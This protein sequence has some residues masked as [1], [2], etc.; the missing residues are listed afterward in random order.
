MADLSHIILPDNTAIDLKMPNI[1]TTYS[2]LTLTNSSMNNG[3]YYYK[4][5]S[6]P[7]PG[8]WYVHAMIIWPGTTNQNG[9][10]VVSITDSSTSET[11]T[12]NSTYIFSRVESVPTASSYIQHTSGLLRTSAAK[13]FYIRVQQNSGSTLSGVGFRIQLVKLTNDYS[14]IQ[15]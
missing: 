12:E 4:Q 10:R 7:S 5:F 8:L 14:M 1:N 6:I 3:T 11:M 2:F 15:N 13:A 9:A